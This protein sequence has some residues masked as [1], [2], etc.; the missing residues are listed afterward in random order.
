MIEILKQIP[1]FAPLSDEDLE[2]IGKNIKME[3]FPA[4]HVIFNEGE[5]GEVMYVIKRGE[6]EILRNNRIIATLK[7]N[8]FFGEMALVS[9]VPRNASIKTL[10]DVEAL[11]LNKADFKH[12]L[13]SNPG[14]ASMVSYE[15]IKR[16]NDRF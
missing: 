12:I 13:E 5:M 4:E 3:Y 8:G 10:C 7:D 11:T 15:V 6:V 1:F 2:V 14:I 16:V 9:D